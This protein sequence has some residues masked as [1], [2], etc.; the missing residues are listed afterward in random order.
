M[1]IMNLYLKKPCVYMC[2]CVRDDCFRLV[3]F[4]S[5]LRPTL[6]IQVFLMKHPWWCSSITIFVSGDISGVFR[7]LRIFKNGQ[8]KTTKFTFKGDGLNY[9]QPVKQWRTFSCD[10]ILG[11][12]GWCSLIQSTN[13]L[14]YNQI[15]YIHI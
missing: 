12:Q 15:K 6:L 2:V 9:F 14:Y 4:R 1:I 10:S 8:S 7:G 11:A 3:V 13:Y 5:W